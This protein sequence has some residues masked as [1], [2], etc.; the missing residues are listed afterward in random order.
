[1]IGYDANEVREGSRLDP[2]PTAIKV[3]ELEALTGADLIISPLDIPCTTPTLLLLHVESGALLVQRK[4]GHDLAS[5]IGDRLLESITK[6]Q[7]FYPQAKCAQWVLL[8]DGSLTENKHNGQA[9]I[10]GRK[11]TT[12]DKAER[13]ITYATIERCIFRW[14]ARGGV[15]FPTNNIPRWCR[16][17]EE[18]LKHF[19]VK[20]EQWVMKTPAIGNGEFLQRARRVENS[21]LML[22]GVRGLGVVRLSKL[23]DACEGRYDLMVQALSTRD[24]KLRPDCVTDYQVQQFRKQG[25]IP[26]NVTYI[27]AHYDTT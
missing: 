4:T 3:P 9:I 6:M 8:F 5:S 17:R 18:D 23:F 22:A 24:K 14:V 26:D 21:K 10:D 19:A 1:M 20:P 2:I 15:Y 11:C 7:E 13:A 16:E 27:G 12:R 25:A